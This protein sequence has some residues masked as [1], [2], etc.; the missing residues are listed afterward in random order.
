VLDAIHDAHA[1]APDD[2]RDAIAPV[3]DLAEP[4]LVRVVEPSVLVRTALDS[5]KS[6]R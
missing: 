4:R 6:V 3:D 1:A 2:L 5:P